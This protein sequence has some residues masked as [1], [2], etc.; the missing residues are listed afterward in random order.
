MVGA[1]LGNVVLGLLLLLLSIMRLSSTPK[2]AQLKATTH[3]QESGHQKHHPEHNHSDAPYKG[4]E[5]QT[6]LR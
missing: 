2:T 5:M 1:H 3:C 4:T 6:G